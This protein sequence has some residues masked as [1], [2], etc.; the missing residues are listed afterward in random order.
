MSRRSASRHSSRPMRGSSASAGGRAGLR[1]ITT[2]GHPPTR[3]TRSARR[4]TSFR[5]LRPPSAIGGVAPRP[6]DALADLISRLIER[7]GGGAQAQKEA[8]RLLRAE[9]LRI[10]KSGRRLG[11]DDKS[12]NFLRIVRE[13]LASEGIRPG[14]SI[15]NPYQERFARPLPGRSHSQYLRDARE[16]ADYERGTILSTRGWNQLPTHQK[17]HQY[18]EKRTR[19]L[20]NTL[21]AIKSAGPQSLPNSRA[22]SST[23]YAPHRLGRT[24][25][26]SKQ[27]L[28]GMEAKMQALTGLAQEPDL[29]R[30][31]AVEGYEPKGRDDTRVSSAAHSPPPRRLGGKIR[32]SR[33]GARSFKKHRGKK[34]VSLRNK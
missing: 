18:L 17:R 30:L 26:E 24:R 31:G 34:N 32:H 13:A 20:G 2:S 9:Y 29:M 16:Q 21:D 19:D 5:S 7:Q 11:H 10:E 15:D 33:R 25:G 14:P 8:S 1:G 4:I 12:I 22:S 27:T 28:R 23:A 6:S 3:P